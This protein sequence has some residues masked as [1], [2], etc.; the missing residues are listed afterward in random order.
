[1]PEMRH[2]HGIQ[3]GPEDN[4]K[5]R[6]CTDKRKARFTPG[7]QTTISLFRMRIVLCAADAGRRQKETHDKQND[8]F[9]FR[10]V[11][12]LIHWRHSRE[13]RRYGRPH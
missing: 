8:P 3:K 11:R 12:T 6:R 10:G 4:E 13:V 9:H 2:I 7:I 5:D 1:M